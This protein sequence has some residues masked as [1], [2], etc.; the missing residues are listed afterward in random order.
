MNPRWVSNKLGAS[1][2]H[3][4]GDTDQRM[5]YEVS[6]LGTAG[7]PLATSVRRRPISRGFSAKSI[8]ACGV[9]GAPGSAAPVDRRWYNPERRKRK[10]YP[11]P[12]PVRRWVQ[13]EDTT[14]HDCPSKGTISDLIH[15]KVVFEV[16]DVLPRS[17]FL[18]VEKE[19]PML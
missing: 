16:K 9:D 2:P 1:P 15:F 19:K 5:A 6:W 7:A 13:A 11:P 4:W 10:F 17:F 18:F 12:K 14:L 3:C 8:S